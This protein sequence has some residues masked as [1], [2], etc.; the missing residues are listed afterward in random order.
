MLMQHQQ[1]NG[2]LSDEEGNSTHKD[3]SYLINL[4]ERLIDEMNKTY[5]NLI[6]IERNPNYE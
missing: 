2:L 1:Q 4:F 6:E 3:L 5:R